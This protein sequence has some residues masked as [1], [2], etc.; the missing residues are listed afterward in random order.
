MVKGLCES[1]SQRVSILGSDML[2]QL[3]RSIEEM[4]KLE[5]NAS[6]SQWQ[7][8]A[9]RARAVAGGIGG[10]VGGGGG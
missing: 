8:E 2:L 6:L 10:R 9:D 4:S 1:G 3:E 7:I 5:S